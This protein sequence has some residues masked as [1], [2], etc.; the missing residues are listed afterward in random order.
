[1][2][3]N[4]VIDILVNTAFDR[5]FKYE[6]ENVPEIFVVMDTLLIRCFCTSKMGNFV[7]N[8]EHKCV[9]INKVILMVT[10][11]KAQFDRFLIKSVRSVFWVY[12]LLKVEIVV[13]GGK[14]L[15]NI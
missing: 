1:M 3:I 6:F 5:F 11:C 9:N 4:F 8:A 12:C 7:K 14:T 2:R 13:F 10:H 15:N